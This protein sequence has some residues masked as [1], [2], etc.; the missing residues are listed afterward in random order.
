MPGARLIR[1]GEGA[2]GLAQA[3]ER[4]VTDV[5]ARRAYRQALNENRA[6]RAEIDALR[7]RI[8]EVEAINAE[9]RETQIEAIRRELGHGKHDRRGV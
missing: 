2:E 4:G 7:T 3:I 9:Y 5:D 1:I 6:L 8:A